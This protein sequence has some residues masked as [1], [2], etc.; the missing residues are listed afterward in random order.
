VDVVEDRPA[1]GRDLEALAVAMTIVPGLMSRNK[2]PS[3]Y[4]NAGIRRA[5]AR[6]LHLRAIVRQLVGARDHVQQ[7]TLRP[8]DDV[9]GACELR[10]RVSAL[11]L[12][13]RAVLSPLEATCVAYLTARAGFPCLPTTEED[14]ARLNAALQSLAHDLELSHSH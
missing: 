12:E 4:E 11:H 7:L 5:R 2:H 1:L 10:Y 13:R 6:A 14:R 8:T 3:L 9:A